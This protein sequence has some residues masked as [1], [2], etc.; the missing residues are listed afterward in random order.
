MTEVLEEIAEFEDEIEII[1]TM[2]SSQLL[3]LAEV[4]STLFPQDTNEPAGNNQAT[5]QSRTA[6]EILVLELEAFQR[7]LKD[8]GRVCKLLR[9]KVCLWPVRFV[10]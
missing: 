1:A 3:F 8:Y 9:K 4:S 10:R 6:F 2:T 5:P 7:E